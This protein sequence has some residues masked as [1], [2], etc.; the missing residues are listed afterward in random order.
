LTPAV[1]RGI[2]EWT[3]SIDQLGAGA[4]YYQYDPKEARRLLAEAGFPQ[5]FITQLT[6]TSGFGRDLLDEAQLLQQYLKDVGIEVEL[7]IQE[8][9]A[10]VATTPVGKAVS[11]LFA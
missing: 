11:R 2:V 5:G 1:T 7:K 6:V 9:G 10:Y 8:F 4:K 3:L